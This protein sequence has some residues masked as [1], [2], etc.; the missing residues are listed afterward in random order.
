MTNR[1][2]LSREVCRR[3][4]LAAQFPRVKT[5]RLNELEGLIH[6]LGFVQLDSINV[7][8]R[9]H[10]L[11]LR[12]R[13]EKYRPEM[14][15]E[16]VEQRRLFEQWTHDAALIPQRFLPYWKRRG[17]R[18][19]EKKQA[20]TVTRLGPN[21]ETMLAEVRGRVEQHGP[22]TSSDFS[23]GE[24]SGSWWGWKPQ[25]VALEYLWRCGELAIHSRRGFR[26]VYE[27]A[28]KVHP[29]HDLVEAASQ[30]AFEDWAVRSALERL[31]A[32]TAKELSDFWGALTREEVAR[33]GERAVQDGVALPVELESA[34]SGLALP[35]WQER[36]D[37]VV[38]RGRRMH[39]LNPFDPLV[40]DRRRLLRL[41]DFH[42]R[43]EAYVPEGK[44][45]HGYFVLPVLQGERFVARVDTKLHRARGEL[46]VRGVWREDSRASSGAFATDL[47]RCLASF[48]VWLGAERF[49]WPPFRTSSAR[50]FTPS[51]APIRDS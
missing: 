11:T 19:R 20:W 37:S 33:A 8:A 22:L 48:A 40:R 50:G 29:D 34:G 47:E 44:R 27:L 43:F 39:L 2:V 51:N 5:A 16:L 30:E 38:F 31:G 1:P 6:Q 7:V 13:M 3:L 12:S 10:H 15:T 46:E 36:V 4:F 9:A 41:F 21:P 26:K 14:L 24:K 17:Q 49:T 35:D 23:E 25:K 45:E 28:S 18:Y 32:A 42:Y